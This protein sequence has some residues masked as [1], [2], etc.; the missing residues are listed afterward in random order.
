MS[1]SF[2]PGLG[3]LWRTAV[4]LFS[5]SATDGAKTSIYVATSPSVA[6]VSG[7]YFVDKSIASLP[8]K[9]LAD[10]QLAS[11]FWNASLKI[12]ADLGYAL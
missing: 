3:F 6:G 4:K 2:V 8:T 7:E 10:P 1:G 11:D 12:L 5:K 9:Q